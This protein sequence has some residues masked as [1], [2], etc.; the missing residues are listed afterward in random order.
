MPEPIA[1][2]YF[3]KGANLYPEGP[4]TGD[5]LGEIIRFLQQ[6]TKHVGFGDQVYSVGV[7]AKQPSIQSALALITDSAIDKPYVILL[8][9]E[10]YNEDVTLKPYVYIIGQ[11]RDITRINGRVIGPAVGS[12]GI[13]NASIV[14]DT[15]TP[16]LDCAAGFFQAVNVDVTNT[17][18]DAN[19]RAIRCSGGQLFF[20][21]RSLQGAI[22]VS[23]GEAIFGTC[24]IQ[25][26][27]GSKQTGGRIFFSHGDLEASFAGQVWMLSGGQFE[28][29]IA[30]LSNALGGFFTLEGGNLKFGTLI[31]KAMGVGVAP[32]DEVQ[33]IEFDL[34]PDAGQWFLEF[35][36][37]TTTALGFG[38]TAGQVESALR[39]L[40]NLEDVTVTGSMAAGFEVT[41]T[42]D[43]GYKPQPELLVTGN[44][45]TQTLNP[46]TP[47]V[48]ETTPGVAPA[49]HTIRQISSGSILAGL[50]NIPAGNKLILGGSNSALVVGL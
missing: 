21:G 30:Y 48:T 46:V 7:D 2:D 13:I 31:Q 28:I 29:G 40:P 45:L 23:G 4:L 38:A 41:F 14:A 34:T 25:N 36:G 49:N 32:V 16:A 39:A 15:A 10:E 11:G 19:A 43:D 8:G 42:G 24:K 47:T 1:I 18:A 37:Q 12:A 27:H 17:S 50:N 20:E 35:D 5:H 33:T 26:H 44:T 6:I 9:P 3:S 22:E